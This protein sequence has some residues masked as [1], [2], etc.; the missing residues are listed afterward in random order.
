MGCLTYFWELNSGPLKKQFVLFNA[1]SSLQSYSIKLTNKYLQSAFYVPKTGIVDVSV[2][3][4]LTF[5]VVLVL[6][7]RIEKGPLEALQV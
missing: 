4:N 3:V 6:E 1:E 7:F 2:T 5:I